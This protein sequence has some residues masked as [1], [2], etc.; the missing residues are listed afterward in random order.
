[1]RLE[2]TRIERD[3]IAERVFK[4]VLEHTN[5][6]HHCI[7]ALEE[8]QQQARMNHKRLE[9]NL[10]QIKNSLGVLRELAYKYANDDTKQTLL[11]DLE[12][13]ERGDEDTG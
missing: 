9:M 3:E 5:Q 4:L 6:M 7:R 2:D 10:D 8:E 11:L 13:L 1:M 12:R